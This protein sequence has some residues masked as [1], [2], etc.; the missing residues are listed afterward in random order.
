MILSILQR[1]PIDDLL[2]II[3]K[4]ILEDLKLQSDSRVCVFLNNAGATSQLEL[5]I[6][7]GKIH[8]HLTNKNI[9][10]ERMY[11]G[12]FITSLDMAGFQICILNLTQH[13]AWL[14]CLDSSTDAPAWPGTDLNIPS[15]TPQNS[16]SISDEEHH[17]FD[18][19]GPKFTQEQIELFEKC[20]NAIASALIKEESRI[21]ELDTL[22]GDGDA[23]STLKR[24]ADGKVTYGLP[25]IIAF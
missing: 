18:K 8:S 24:F 5:S 25:I 2:E 17:G 12:D 10:V 1:P 23:G 4:R 21:N 16:I 20:L 7:I 9:T 22:S 11:C 15:E 14:E 13:P 6:I 19:T 3:L